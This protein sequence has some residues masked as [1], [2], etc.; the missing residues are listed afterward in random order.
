MLYKFK[1]KAAGDVIMLEGNGRQVL[2]IIGKAPDAKGIILPE[3]MPAAIEAL[4]AAIAQEEAERDAAA[5][6]AQA[7]ND[8]PPRGEAVSLRQ[9]AHPFIAML[10]V[11]QL[12]KK[13]IV[14][15]V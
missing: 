6:Q 9:R 15:G 1:S 12:A 11:C 10:K 5:A 13:E 8:T 4:Q 7:A 14:W 3:Q 2:E